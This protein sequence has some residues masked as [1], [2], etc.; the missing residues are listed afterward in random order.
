MWNSTDNGVEIYSKKSSSH[1]KGRDWGING[2][3]KN[4]LEKVDCNGFSPQS[5]LLLA[6]SLMKAQTSLGATLVRA[7]TSRG[8]YCCTRESHSSRTVAGS[9]EHTLSRAAVISA[10][11]VFASHLFFIHQ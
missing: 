9:S 10:W 8:V 7:S 11:G 1:K 6:Q 3:Q 4:G 5:D 2:P